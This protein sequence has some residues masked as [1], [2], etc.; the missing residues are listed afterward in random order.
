MNERQGYGGGTSS[1]RPAQGD[2]AGQMR[3]Q[4]EHL[5]DRA[6]NAASE[7]QDRAGHIADEA[8]ARAEDAAD[9]GRERAADGM[10]R[11]ASMLHEHEGA[12]AVGAVAGRAAIGMERSAQYLRERDTSEMWTDVEH[13]IREHPAQGIAGAM[14]AGFLIGRI[15][16]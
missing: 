7:A 5:K 9:M 11:A 10:E 1:G 13:Y 2:Q 12:G 4:G 15:L 3:E 14:A 16:R 8:R 6:E